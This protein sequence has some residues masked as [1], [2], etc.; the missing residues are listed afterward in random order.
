MVAEDRSILRG[1]EALA[2]LA[3]EP[4]CVRDAVDVLV[5]RAVDIDPE[6]LRSA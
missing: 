4:E 1:R 3:V 6:Q 2:C 5:G